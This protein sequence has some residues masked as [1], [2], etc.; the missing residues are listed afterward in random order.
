MS[1]LK[2]RFFI[3]YLFI[4]DVLQL[5]SFQEKTYIFRHYLYLLLDVCSFLVEGLTFFSK[6]C[7]RMFLTSDATSVVVGK[8]SICA[9]I[10]IKQ[11]IWL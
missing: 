9:R 3:Y 6:H 2:T 11:V 5:I 7:E 1:K 8:N 4:L 10:I